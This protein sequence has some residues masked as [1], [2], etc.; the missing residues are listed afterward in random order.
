MRN[1]SRSGAIE[2]CQSLPN[3]TRKVENYEEI[4]LQKQL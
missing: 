2:S 4:L 3:R 1:L